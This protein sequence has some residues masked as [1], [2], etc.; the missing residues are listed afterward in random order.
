MLGVHQDIQDKVVQ[1]LNDIFQKSDRPVTFA[2]TIE[3]KL[4]ERVIMET[5]RLYPPVPIIARRINEECK[6]GEFAV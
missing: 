4:L 2:D 5:L 3:M 6:L 1:E